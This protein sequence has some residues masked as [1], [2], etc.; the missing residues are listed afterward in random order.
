[1]ENIAHISKDISQ[2]SKTLSQS[3]LDIVCELV[4]FVK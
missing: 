4:Y 2:Y 1:M 3:Q